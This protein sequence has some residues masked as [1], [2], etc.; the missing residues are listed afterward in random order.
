MTKIK[1]NYQESVTAKGNY[2]T[3]AIITLPDNTHLNNSEL[4]FFASNQWPTGKTHQ[5]GEESKNAFIDKRKQTELK[6]KILNQKDNKLI[7]KFPIQPELYTLHFDTHK[8]LN[9]LQLPEIDLTITKYPDADYFISFL[10]DSILDDFHNYYFQHK[11]T[12]IAYDIYSTNNKSKRPLIIFLHGSGERGFGNRLPLL[13]CAF[14]QKVLRYAK[15]KEDAVILV[16]QATWDNNLHGWFKEDILDTT[17]LLIKTT[18]NQ[19]NIDSNRVYLVG[20]SNGGATTWHLAANHPELFAAI[21]PCCGYIYQSFKNFL[22]S[23]STGRYM[24]PTNEE[25]KQLI[26]MPIW[27]FAAKDDNIVNPKGTINTIK[28]LQNAGNKSAKATLYEPG[29]VSP[30]PHNSWELAYENPEL[31]PW[32]FAQH[33]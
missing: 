30:S 22:G 23:T 14:P 26:N 18:I 2:V 19:Y 25:I 1:V 17:Y 9:Y 32:L 29:T 31:L 24:K 28:A 10:H 4:N 5:V 16:P 7:I 3:K 15:E 12:Q 27:A 6:F 11:G 8:F 33:K 13:G 20:L 21:S